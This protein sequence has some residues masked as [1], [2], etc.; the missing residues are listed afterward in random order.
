MKG[1]FA[2]QRIDRRKFSIQECGRDL[3][4]L[5][6]EIMAE[7]YDPQYLRALSGYDQL[8]EIVKL[9]E[10][11]IEGQAAIEERFAAV[12]KLLKS[13]KL[14]DF[15][16]DVET[17]VTAAMD[18][19]EEQQRRIDFLM[20][21]SQMLGQAQGA[22][23]SAPQIMPLVGEMLLYGVRSFRGGRTLEAEFERVIE[24]LK[25]Q[26]M[27]PPGQAG[28]ETAEP[29]PTPEQQQADSVEA[30]TKIMAANAKQAE[31]QARVHAAQVKAQADIQK[32]KDDATVREIQLGG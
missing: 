16:I 28:G 2:G 9:R 5:K 8:T 10:F 6:A 29:G 7:L 25:A 17:D 3:M 18:G 13:D 20:A 30:Q 1:R 23:E 21:A 24:E 27:P 31:I 26:P 14:R 19:P 32:A 15:R 12:I 4:R 22:M 11:G